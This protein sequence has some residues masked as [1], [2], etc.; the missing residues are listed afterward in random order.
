MDNECATSKEVETG[1]VSKRKCVLKFGLPS[2]TLSTT[3]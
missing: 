2:P 3:G 1:N